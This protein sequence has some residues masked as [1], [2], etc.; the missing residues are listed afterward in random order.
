MT[1]RKIRDAVAADVLRRCDELM[2]A[3]T[4]TAAV[5]FIEAER[6]VR[7]MLPVSVRKALIG[8]SVASSWTSIENDSDLGPIATHVIGLVGR[9]DALV[10]LSRALQEM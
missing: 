10:L 1:P 7:Q 8:S 6:L 5:L 9:A 4:A 3:A 2:V